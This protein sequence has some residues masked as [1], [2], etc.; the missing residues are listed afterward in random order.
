M[1]SISILGLLLL[2]QEYRCIKGSIAAKKMASEFDSG[3][4]KCEVAGCETT[5]DVTYHVEEKKNLCEKCAVE[6]K[7][8]RG[9]GE[10]KS[11]RNWSCDKHNQPISAYCKNHDQYLCHLC[12]VISHQKECQL[13]DVV[14]IIAEK[15]SRIL[16]LQVSARDRTS[17]WK[18]HVGGIHLYE[19]DIKK[20]LSGVREQIDYLINSEISKEKERVQREA[21]S[22]SKAADDEIRKIREKKEKCQKRCDENANKRLE[23]IEEKRRKFHDDVTMI[24][25]VTTEYTGDLHKQ[26]AELVQ[27]IDLTTKKLENFLQDDKELINASEQVIASLDEKLKKIAKNED[28]VKEIANT[29]EGV[30]FVEGLRHEKYNGRIDGY[31]GD[32]EHAATIKISD[33]DKIPRIAGYVNNTVVISDIYPSDH[34]YLL[35][36]GDKTTTKIDRNGGMLWS[37][38]QLSKDTIICGMHV[39]GDATDAINIYDRQWNLVKS[40]SL[41]RKTS[42]DMWVNVCVDEDG[43]IIAAER[44]TAKIYIIKPSDGAI[45]NTITCKQAIKL[46]GTLSSGEFIALASPSDDRLLIIDRKGAQREISVGGVVSDCAIDSLTQDLYPVYRLKAQNWYHINHLSS[47]GEQ[48]KKNILQYTTKLGS[49]DYSR[50]IITP[51]GWFIICDGRECR[52]YH[53]FFCF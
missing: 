53:K 33:D 15:K 18:M 2:F 52:V 25:K 37:C 12:A 28:R 20:H 50:L 17:E 43:M 23:L 46:C 51:S 39:T 35:N 21:A 1:K 30:R 44:D 48:Q 26:T 38:A 32:W 29:I 24:S 19:G 34:L 31:D 11:E 4:K 40:I 10:R 7:L 42:F 8:V 36:P 27:A 47:E 49:N 3:K 9:A 6:A 41:P 45:V 5:T 13:E 14:D 22:I 16:E